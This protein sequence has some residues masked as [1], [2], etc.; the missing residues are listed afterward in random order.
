V[1]KVEQSEA[2][3]PDKTQPPVNT[4]LEHPQQYSLAP[5]MH[6]YALA[7]DLPSQIMPAKA[8]FF[9]VPET[10]LD[11]LLNQQPPPFMNVAEQQIDPMLMGH[12]A[13]FE[14]AQQHHG[15][16]HLFHPGFT[17]SFTR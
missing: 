5:E 9:T 8:P 7:Q 11:P 2:A 10:V 15:Q 6:Q 13:S 17:P 3:R 16:Q 14:T 4:L 12:T 1:D